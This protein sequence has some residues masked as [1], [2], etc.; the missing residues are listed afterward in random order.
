[1]DIQTN[2]LTPY[3]GVCGFFLQ[4]KFDTEVSFWSNLHDFIFNVP[5]SCNQKLKHLFQILLNI[6]NAATNGEVV[7]CYSIGLNVL[8]SQ[9]GSIKNVDETHDLMDEIHDLVS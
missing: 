8:K 6:E 7:E 3:K 1:M 2:S 9:L 4:V 5:W